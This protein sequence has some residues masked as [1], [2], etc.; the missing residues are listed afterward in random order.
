[1]ADAHDREM[2]QDIREASEPENEGEVEGDFPYEDYL[3]GKSALLL[4]IFKDPII[5]AVTKKRV[6]INNRRGFPLAL[7]Y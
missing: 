7:K 4:F 5:T 6:A 1:M 2:T 3:T